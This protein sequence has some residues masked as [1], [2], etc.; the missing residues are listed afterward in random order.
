VVIDGVRVAMLL[1]V[2]CDYKQLY[3]YW[4]VPTYIESLFRQ[5]VY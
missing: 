4:E 1:T 2:A 3:I 5:N